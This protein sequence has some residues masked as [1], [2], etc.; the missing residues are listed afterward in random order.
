[1][2]NT[3]LCFL[4]MDGVLADFEGGICASLGRKSPYLD[5]ASY[6]TFDMEKL[7]N[8]S[9]EEFWRGT[10]RNGFWRDLEKTPE[11]DAIVELACSTFGVDNVCILT[12]PSRDSRCIPEKSQWIA[13]HYPHLRNNMLFGS[14]KRFLAG[15]NRLLL[16]DRDANIENFYQ[17]GGWGI[18]VP[19]LWNNKYQI[20][21]ECLA[22]IK[23]EVTVF[24]DWGSLYESPQR[25]GC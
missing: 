19:R 7:W 12:A 20:A 1:M 18:T 2:A 14:A 5:A 15:P 23:V 8:I 25:H 24:H 4:D 22:E 10:Q 16:D 21:K 17:A 11:A 3:T 9:A 6:G 13:K